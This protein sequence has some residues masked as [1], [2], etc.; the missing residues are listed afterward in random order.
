MISIFPPFI[1]NTPQKAWFSRR[2]NQRFG[3]I[4]WHMGVGLISG[5]WDCY[6]FSWCDP[7]R[8]AHELIRH[9]REVIGLIAA[10]MFFGTLLML[11][12]IWISIVPLGHPTKL[13]TNTIDRCWEVSFTLNLC[14]ILWRKS[15]FCS[16]M[17]DPSWS[18]T[19][20]PCQNSSNDWHGDACHVV[21]GQGKTLKGRTTLFSSWV[22]TYSFCYWVFHRLHCALLEMSWWSQVKHR[23]I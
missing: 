1:L 20:Q 11:K 12:P 15:M 6:G 10:N 22:L 23:Y 8:M 16:L 17:T 21:T 7:H 19:V 4:Q 3:T 9:P 5:G 14:A 18:V 13:W 2:W